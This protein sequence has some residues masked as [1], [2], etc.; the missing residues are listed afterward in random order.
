MKW[1]NSKALLGIMFATA[2]VIANLVATKVAVFDLPLF[3]AVAVPAGFAAIGVSFLCT[4]LLGELHGRE[5][6]RD[7]VNATVVALAVAWGLVYGAVAFPAAPFYQDA[8]AFNRIFSASGTI[9]LAGITTTLVSQNIDVAIF[10]RLKSLTGGDQ[11]W[12]RNLGSTGLSQLVDTSLFIILAFALFPRLPFLS[13]TITPW[14]AIPSLVIG[15]Y[16]VKMVVAALD[17]PVFYALTRQ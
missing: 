5:A 13:G 9:V 7:A 8:A 4:D 11:K 16:A 14:A 2:I 10:H 3:G 6:A 1:T 17:T 12:L 15:Q